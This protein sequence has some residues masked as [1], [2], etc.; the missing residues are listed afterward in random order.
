[1]ASKISKYQYCVDVYHNEEKQGLDR[2][3]G[4]NDRYIPLFFVFLHFFSQKVS[5]RP[6]DLDNRLKSLNHLVYILKI[7]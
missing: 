6:T 2:S 7:G 4:K 5:N 1:M 3:E